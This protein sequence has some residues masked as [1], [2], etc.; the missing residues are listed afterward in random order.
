MTSEKKTI[1]VVDDDAILLD[2]LKEILSDIGYTVLTASNGAVAIRIYQKQKGNIDLIL[3]DVFMTHMNGKETFIALRNINR[4]V[5][6]VFIS[7]YSNNAIIQ[8]ALQLGGLA[9][10]KKPFTVDELTTVVKGAL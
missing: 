8:E 10:L 5:K 9:F 4:K 2:M 7:G 3:L 6:C 1:L